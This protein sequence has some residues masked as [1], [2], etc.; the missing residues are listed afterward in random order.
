MLQ[1]EQI[2]QIVGEVF[3]SMLSWSVT[4][5]PESNGDF[6][7]PLGEMISS[8]VNITGGW[9]GTVALNF[10]IAVAQKSAESMFGLDAG[11]SSDSEL[12]D[13]V[14]ELANM[15]G[16]NFKSLQ[17]GACQLSLPSVVRGENFHVSYPGSTQLCSLKFASEH[18]TMNVTLFQKH[19]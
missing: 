3:S 9:N 12:Q 16:G 14:G 13:A 1:E 5:Q 11:A 2:N 4:P 15:V 7:P 8:C 10:P 17:E 6:P 19:V 18:G